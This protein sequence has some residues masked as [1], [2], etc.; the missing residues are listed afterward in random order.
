MADDDLLKRAKM[1]IMVANMTAPSISIQ[2]G[3]TSGGSPI[4]V[5]P[6]PLSP[7]KRD[8]ENSDPNFV[9]IKAS[10]I[11]GSSLITTAADIRNMVAKGGT[12][13]IDGVSCKIRE[14]D[15]EW[16]ANR[17]ELAHDFQG[18]TNFEAVISIPK[19]KIRN[20]K[21]IKHVAAPIPSTDI[22]QAVQGLELLTSNI[23]NANDGLT[24]KLLSPSK[25][26]AKEKR[27]TFD[28]AGYGHGIKLESDISSYLS[29]ATSVAKPASA[30]IVSTTSSGLSSIHDAVS[31]LGSSSDQHPP[32]PSVFPSLFGE[33]AQTK[34][35]EKILT[36]QRKAAERIAEWQKKQELKMLEKQLD[37]NAAERRLRRHPPIEPVARGGG[38]SGTGKKKKERDLDS[39][40][41]TERSEEEEKRIEVEET[42]AKKNEANQLKVAVL[43]EKTEKRVA[44]YKERLAREQQEAQLRLAAE[45]EQRSLR[46]AQVASKEKQDKI[47]AMRK[48][49]KKRYR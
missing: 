45:E 1:L 16:A 26:K 8:M 9:T 38:P 15:G 22:R 43:R 31:A 37:M 40:C 35:Q 12:I 5:K 14:A 28:S 30:A 39:H 46:S 20:N 42:L 49:T 3:G 10:V 7:I 33:Q 4:P 18:P 17:I 47:A 23:G 21:T 29:A 19:A 24:K 41:G 6:G 25:K 11:N 32:F 27:K 48:E 34:R 44:E 36:E 2:N 13:S